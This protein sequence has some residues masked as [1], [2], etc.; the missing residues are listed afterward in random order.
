[1]RVD[2]GIEEEKALHHFVLAW[3]FGEMF[4]VLAEVYEKYNADAAFE[5]MD[6]LFPL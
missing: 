5:L 6:P 3:F 2:H 1:M 4:V